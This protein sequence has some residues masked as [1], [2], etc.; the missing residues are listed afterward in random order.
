MHCPGA[1]VRNRGFAKPRNPRRGGL[2]GAQTELFIWRFRECALPGVEVR[3]PFRL[4]DGSL[5]LTPCF[6]STAQKAW[7]PQRS[8]AGTPGVPNISSQR[9]YWGGFRGGGRRAEPGLRTSRQEKSCGHSRKRKKEKGPF[10]RAP[11]RLKLQQRAKKRQRASPCGGWSEG[12]TRPANLT[13][14]VPQRGKKSLRPFMPRRGTAAKKEPRRGPPR[15]KRGSFRRT[16]F[17]LKESKKFRLYKNAHPGLWG[18][19]GPMNRHR[20]RKTGA[21]RTPGPPRS[22][23]ILLRQDGTCHGSERTPPGPP[24]FR[25]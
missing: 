12:R 2:L 15:H 17:C 16:A 23:S 21:V 9:K 10:R 11:S 8:R 19:K 6:L 13:P 24:N 1:G 14:P 7:G 5:K 22:C 20:G 3:R 25:V 4:G 18:D